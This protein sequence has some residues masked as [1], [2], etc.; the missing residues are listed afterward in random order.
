MRRYHHSD[1]LAVPAKLSIDFISMASD[2]VVR[3]NS[4]GIWMK[5]A[6]FDST[7]FVDVF[8]LFPVDF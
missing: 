6:A 1:N 2:A 7:S 8:T 5:F 4:Y 3:T